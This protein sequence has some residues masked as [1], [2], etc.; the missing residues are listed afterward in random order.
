[1]KK[2]SGKSPRLRLDPTSYRDL[3]RQVLERDVTNPGSVTAP[4][5]AGTKCHASSSTPT[6][7]PVRTIAVAHNPEQGQYHCQQNALFDAH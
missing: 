2:V 6:N 7:T 3:H 1:M 5:T 4:G